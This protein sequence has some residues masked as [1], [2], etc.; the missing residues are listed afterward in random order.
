MLLVKGMIM[1]VRSVGSTLLLMFVIIYVF[2]ILFTQLLRT[3][4]VGV[5]RFETVPMAI[6]YLLLGSVFPD[7]KNDI[8]DMLNAHGIYYML[9][10]L[11][12][13]LGPTTV[14]N[15]L[16]G[17]LVEVVKVVAEAEKVHTEDIQLKE[18]F[19]EMM[20]AIDLNGDNIVDA[21]ELRQVMYQR[22]AVVLLNNMGIDVFA[23][24]DNVHIIFERT[25]SMNVDEL[26]EAIMRF[27][28]TNVA[29][30]KDVIGIKTA[31]K[32]ECAAVVEHVGTL[33]RTPRP[34]PPSTVARSR[35]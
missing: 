18:Q 8:Q 35:Q 26:W 13:L 9:M 15:M 23:L 29:R 12:L 1:A 3:E 25:E 16:I 14:M 19:I 4:P 24:V 20:R 33:L 27:R 34:E 6:N 28:E 32:Y 10:I 21:D 17:V 2:A 22:E 30:Q 11:Y 5:G 31:L 7:Q